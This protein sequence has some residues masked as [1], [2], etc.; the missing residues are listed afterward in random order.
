MSPVFFGTLH[1]TGE[2]AQH[3]A[4]TQFTPLQPHHTP[5]DARG[6]SQERKA[7][8]SVGQLGPNGDACT[9]P[10]TQLRHSL[11]QPFDHL[12]VANLELECL[13]SIPRAIELW[14]LRPVI[15][16]QLRTNRCD[17]THTHVLL[18]RLSPWEAHLPPP[19]PTPHSKTHESSV[20]HSDEVPWLGVV[21]TIPCDQNLHFEA[22]HLS[23]MHQHHAEVVVL[24]V[25]AAQSGHCVNFSYPAHPPAGTSAL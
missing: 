24:I 21:Q 23:R 14:S 11:V 8:R 22:T 13:L 16:G 17:D 1:S 25:L 18:K 5:Q 10:E 15:V 6:D 3:E 2:R 20:V 12:F 19:P 4:R 9:F 7:R